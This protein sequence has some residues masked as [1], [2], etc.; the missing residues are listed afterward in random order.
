MVEQNER[1]AWLNMHIVQQTFELRTSARFLRSAGENSRDSRDAGTGA[2][3]RMAKS[4]GD[5][6]RDSRGIRHLSAVI[7]AHSGALTRVLA[8]RCART[9]TQRQACRI[10]H[11]KIANHK[12]RHIIVYSTW[13]MRINEAVPMV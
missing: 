12:S 6:W 10:D 1:V 3:T 5:S 8:A 4:A 13:S 2:G 9:Y 11:E 7:P